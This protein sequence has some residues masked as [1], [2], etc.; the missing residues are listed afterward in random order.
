MTA[1]S[2][3][4]QRGAA[5]LILVTVLVLGIAWFTVGALGKAAPTT[6]ETETQTGAALQAGKQ[7]LLAYVA[8][9]A[10]RSGT[11]EPGQLPCPE[12]LTLSSPGQSSTS[13]SA[14]A[15]VVGRLPWRTLGIDQL[16]DGDGEPLWYMMQGFRNPP[17][18]FGTA[19]QLIYN[20]SQVVAMIIAPGRPLNTL[21]VSGAPPAGCTQQNQLVATRNTAT[22]NPA[23][24]IECGITTGSLT[25]PGNATW[26]ND[27]VIAITAA[28]WADAIAP[29]VA[30]RLQRQVAPALEDWRANQSLATWGSSFLPYASTFSDPATNDVCGN[31]GVLEGQTPAGTSPGCDTRWTGATVTQLAG[32]LNAGATCAQVG[33]G[34]NNFTCT[35][36]SLLTGLLAVRVTATAP[37]IGM[38]FRDRIAASDI[39]NNSG[40]SVSSGPSYAL[41]SATGSV[42]MQ[43][44]I[45]FPLVIGFVPI[46]VTFP[47]LPNAAVLSDPRVAWFVANN[48]GAYTY[49]DVSPAVTLNPGAATC[50]AGGGAQCLTVNGWPASNGNA[51]DKRFVL[52]LMGRAVAGQT[53]PSG[54][55]ANYLESHTVSSTLFTAQTVTST[56]NDRLAACPFQQTAAGPAT[57]TICN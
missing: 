41:S 48:W 47:N 50:P 44:N 33:G 43:F 19:G 57:V 25:A 39:Q 5:L 14:T 17:I 10:A 28:E 22:L 32:I 38:S 23:N 21:P 34:S 52:T 16:R 30:D 20:G 49:Y 51:N 6:A 55:P 9:Y 40:G 45:T 46:T 1:R 13:C 37:N 56:F 7:A 4:R 36:T 15:I 24:F 3:A 27:R 2:A 26:T 31:Y 53:Q 54:N 12:S 8:Q 18:N 42:T 35:F 11:A 29:A